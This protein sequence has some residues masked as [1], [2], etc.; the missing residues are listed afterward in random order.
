MIFDKLILV[1]QS[2]VH[3]N[4]RFVRATEKLEKVMRAKKLFI[5]SRRR[6]GFVLRMRVGSRGWMIH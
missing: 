3:I 6:G 5:R 2:Y 4:N 1:G